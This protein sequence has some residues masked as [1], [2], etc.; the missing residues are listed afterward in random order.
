MKRKQIQYALNKLNYY[1]CS[2]DSLYGQGTE[3]ALPGY[4]NAKGLNGRSLHSIF[5]SA[6]SQVSVQSSFAVAKRFTNNASRSLSSSSGGASA[7]KTLL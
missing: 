5:S 6:L 4:A 1:N 3:R 2:I 7:G